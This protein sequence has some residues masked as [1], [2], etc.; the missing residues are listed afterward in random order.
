MLVLFQAVEQ[1]YVGETITMAKS[2]TAALRQG[3]IGSR[4]LL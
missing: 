2:V 1:L 3:L 4:P